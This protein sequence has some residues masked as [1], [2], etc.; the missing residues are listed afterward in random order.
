MTT[1]PQKT[2]IEDVHAYWNA[3]SCGTNVA[4]AQKH[5]RDYFEEIENFRYTH[6][7]F[8]HSFAQFTR[9]N[10]KRM[11][12]VGVGAGSDFLQFVR[13]GAKANGIDLTQE[14]VENVRNRLAV[15]GLAAESLQVAN[16]EKIPFADDSFDLVYSWG[17]IHHSSDPLAAFREI[18]RVTKPGGT[19]KVM[20]Y[21]L[22][23]V[24][25]W[26]RFFAHALPRGKIING[27]RWALAR[28]QESPGTQAYT[29]R[30]MR[31]F[32]KQYN[33]EDLTFTFDDQIIR[34]GARLCAIRRI[35]RA[36]T[37]SPFR[38]YMGMT[39]RKPE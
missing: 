33:V 28:Y 6:E 27:R 16:A 31:D 21:N 29:W 12:E 2:A 32:L 36:L 5:S 11:L 8:I 7:P 20:V 25:T 3:G 19:V 1:Q 35:V 14:G 13:A 24:H 37:P 15:Y 10:G 23:A 9:W 26:F 18:I 17:V 30:E 39:F 4:T 38:W 34:K 22:N